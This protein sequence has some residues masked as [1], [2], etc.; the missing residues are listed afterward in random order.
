M[1]RTD[2]PAL[3]RVLATGAPDPARAQAWAL[4]DGGGH[5][6]RTGRSVPGEWPDA[7][8]REA[9]VAAS[10]VRIIALALPPMPAARVAAAARYA[11]DDQFA[12][13]PDEMHVAV[14]AAPVNGRVL[15]TVV[16]NALIAALAAQRPA[17][18]RVIAEP[19]L[20]PP[21]EG[22][23]WC[24]GGASGDF[25]RREDGSAFPIAPGATVPPPELALALAQAARAG[26]VP[27]RVV[28]DAEVDDAALAAATRATGIPFI[29][30][31]PWQWHAAPVAVFV[32]AP[33]LLQG[34]FSR[35]P[36]APTGARWRGFRP[37]L[38]LA[39]LAL[40]LH[41]VATLGTWA[42]QRIEAWQTDRAWVEL[43]HQA[44]IA[45][46]A[47]ADAARAAI[48]R[49]YAERRHAAGL[50]APDDALTLLARSAPALAA[51]P[52]GILKRATYASGAWTLE[53]APLDAAARAAFDAR[54][55][56]AGVSALQ[57]TT[58]DGWRVRIGART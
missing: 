15:A 58:A 30:N 14:E 46:V 4:Y 38:A 6:I 54:L 16:S 5:V 21:T 48:G 49:R 39:A 7:E 8:R 35:Q 52:P 10:A 3:L 26:T 44:G 56:G 25:V 29:R 31:D 53:L 37:A 55:A 27:K 47:S 43:A 41:V 1:A 23:R 9:V 22:W 19:A 45:D 28:A 20:A 40:G 51:L 2:L 34:E 36:K 33:D 42:W 50:S 32:R 18:A 17:F 11:L 24:Q 57:A 13:P 12:A